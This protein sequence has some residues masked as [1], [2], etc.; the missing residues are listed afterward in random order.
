[1]CKTKT[2]GNFFENND[3]SV[4]TFPLLVINHH[5]FNFSCSNYCQNSQTLNILGTLF[6]KN[7]FHTFITCNCSLF[8][9]T[10][11]KTSLNTVRVRKS[12]FQKNSGHQL[13]DMYREVSKLMQKWQR[14]GEIRQR[15]LKPS[16]GYDLCGQ[17]SKFCAYFLV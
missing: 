15:P 9:K 10:Y 8:F 7:T 2:P 14:T 12:C 16:I 17:A 5:H 13:H 11:H 1:M 4:S 6:T 3:L